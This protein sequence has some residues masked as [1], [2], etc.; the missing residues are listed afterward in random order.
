[1][2]GSFKKLTLFSCWM[3]LV[4]ILSCSKDSTGPQETPPELPPKISFV[5]DFSGFPSEG[6]TSLPKPGDLQ[7]QSRQNW[8]W[9]AANVVVWNTVITVNLIVPVTAFL[10]SFNHQPVRQAAGHWMWTY[11]F[12]VGND[13]FTAELHGMV[14]GDGIDWEMYIS[15]QGA[16]SKFLWY[17]GGADLAYTH[18]EWTLNKD[19]QNAVPYIEIAWNRNVQDSTADIKYTNV[20][21]DN[22][23]VGSYIWYGVTNEF[24]YDLFYEIYA[25]QYQNSTMIQWSSDSKAGRVRDPLH[26]E[27]SLWHCWNELLEDAECPL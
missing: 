6:K 11:N 14:S 26:F 1:M 10:V 9:A 27:N 2:I 17:Y 20:M 4:L 21:E 23:D 13:Q 25:E 18:G 24:P 3:V 22:A 15:K 12:N 5:M 8:G 19:P 16:Y 7:F